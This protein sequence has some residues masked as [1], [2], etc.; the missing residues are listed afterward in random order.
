MAYRVFLSSTSKDLAVHRE[1]VHRAID[2]LDGF[3]PIRM[4]SFGARDTDARKLG[5]ADLLLGLLGHCYGSS[6]PDDPTSFTEQEYDFALRWELP[7]LMFVAPDDFLVPFHLI[8]P[9]DKRARQQAF[10]ARVMID[11]VVASFASPD[12]LARSVNTALANWRADR[13]RAEEITAELMAT[14]AERDQLQQALAEGQK[15]REALR[16]AIMALTGRARE[17]GAPGKIEHALDLL[18]EGQTAEAEAIFAEIVDRK[19]AEGAAALQE[20][21]E[22]AR[23]LG[24][25]A[26]LDS[27]QK[28]TAAYATAT[29]LD[30]NHTWSWIFLG[31]LHKRAGSL[32]QAEHAF[33]QALQA[34]IRTG[35]DRDQS[36]AQACLGDIR[37]AKGNLRA[38][39]TAYDAALS[40]QHQL[41][42][43]D[44]D[45]ADWQ[46]DLSVSYDRIGDVRVAQ[47]D[48]AGALEAYEQGRGIREKLAA[49]DPDNA[50]WQRDLIVSHWRL[51][52]LAEQ[53]SDG[54]T[55]RRHWQAALAI[56]KELDATGRLAPPDAYFVDTIEARLV[57]LSE[58]QATP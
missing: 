34:A 30:P 4:E 51:A 18:R 27:T 21:A 31:L 6:P 49:R 19:E 48:R 5:E 2:A 13:E 22:A 9:D 43:R 41:A 14:K 3:D 56:A 17:A 32:T 47:G 45:N 15:E 55:A 46:R 11:R 8:E 35:H 44:P 33:D 1:A 37:R 20:A 53:Q 7:R 26:Y 36:V 39:L 42:A 52:D 25:L 58:E 38:A 16:A 54:A 24:A 10:R 28:A 57:Q 40:I 29:R 12:E 50:D 23:H